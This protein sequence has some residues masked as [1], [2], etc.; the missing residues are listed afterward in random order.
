MQRYF[1][2]VV[3]LKIKVYILNSCIMEIKVGRWKCHW[4]WSKVRK[5][6]KNKVHTNLKQHQYWFYRIMQ[7][8]FQHVIMLLYIKSL[9][10]NLYMLF[11]HKWYG[12]S[13]LVK[14]KEKKQ[15][16]CDKFKGF[17]VKFSFS[18]NYVY[19]SSNG[20]LFLT[21]HLCWSVIQSL[22]VYTY[23]YYGYRS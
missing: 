9:Q 17:R 23:E 10:F 21:C 5:R 1:R 15:Q 13:A 6:G 2:L 8:H 11:S 18:I 20:T 7:R 12:E 4:S 16:S 3:L 14:I 22:H 19:V